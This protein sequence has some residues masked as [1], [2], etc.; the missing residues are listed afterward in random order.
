MIL[1]IDNHRILFFLLPKKKVFNSGTFTPR[2]STPP[3]AQTF[4]L[5][6]N[7]FAIDTKSLV[8]FASPKSSCNELQNR[9][10]EVLG[11]LKR[12]ECR[13][14]ITNFRERMVELVE[15]K[16]K[17]LKYLIFLPWLKFFSYSEIFY[18]CFFN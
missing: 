13:N 12:S 3:T 15:A 11:G 6:E 2:S 1:V 8:S 18:R 9:L 14:S 7:L 10:K 17:R 16:G 4:N 5:L